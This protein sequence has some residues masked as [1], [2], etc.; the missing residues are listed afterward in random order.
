MPRRACP[1]LRRRVSVWPTAAKAGLRPII[2][3][4]RSTRYAHGLQRAAASG[5]CGRSPA[6]WRDVGTSP[7]SKKRWVIR[8]T[9]QKR[10]ERRWAAPVRWTDPRGYPMT[11]WDAVGGT[12]VNQVDVNSEPTVIFWSRLR[13]VPRTKS[14]AHKRPVVSRA[15]NVN[16]ATVR[17]AIGARRV[18]TAA[19]GLTE[20]AAR[21]L[22]ERSAAIGADGWSVVSRCAT[23]GSDHDWRNDRKPWLASNGFPRQLRMATTLNAQQGWAGCRSTLRRAGYERDLVQTPRLVV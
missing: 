7:W 4:S 13:R 21:A 22:R 2:R 20:P 8:L 12:T 18:W 10:S 11:R 5:A 14:S 15:R 17:D 23:R 16:V 1:A 19:R 3:W 9:A 6:R